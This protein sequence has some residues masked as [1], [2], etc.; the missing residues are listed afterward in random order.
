MAN[1]FFPTNKNDKEKLHAI[2]TASAILLASG[3]L[4]IIFTKELTI[5]IASLLGG[6]AFMGYDIYTSVSKNKSEDKTTDKF[7]KSFKIQNDNEMVPK[8]IDK[9]EHENGFNIVFHM[10][11]GITTKAFEK[12]IQAFREKYN[13]ND[14]RFEY[15]GNQKILMKAITSKLEDI[16]PFEIIPTDEIL[17]IPLGRTKEG[18]IAMVNLMDTECML[19]IAGGTGSG[20]TVCLLVIITYLILEKCKKYPYFINLH[21]NDLKGGSGLNRFEFCKYVKS[22]STKPQD[23]LK[24]LQNAL[25]ILAERRKL[26]NELRVYDIEEYNKKYGKIRG[27]LPYE[28]IIIDEYAQLTCR[29]KESKEIMHDLA[30]LGRSF[31]IRLIITTQ[32][33][34]V[35]VIDGNIKNNFGARICFAV[36]SQVDSKTVLDTTGGEKLTGNGHGILSVA[37]KIEFRNFYIDTEQIEK[38]IKNTIEYKTSKE[39]NTPGTEGCMKI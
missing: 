1:P 18:K 27:Y 2:T 39:N 26:F 35:E 10:P 8:I 12:N 36:Q 19:L 5:S 15:I 30:S 7:F 25:T 6:I 31:G 29:I 17:K 22:Y 14:I 33:P 13:C 34:T 37:K 32:R 23:T 28:I 24:L 9:K 4:G 3:S 21:L 38:L 16:Y 11:L 20:K